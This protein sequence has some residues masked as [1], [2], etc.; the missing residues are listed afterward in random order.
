M[1]KPKSLVITTLL[2]FGAL[3]AFSQEK[4]MS[5]K[6]IRRANNLTWEGNQE[7]R[8]DNFVDAEAKY[9]T[10]I[11]ANE[12]EST[13]KYNLGNTYFEQKSYEEALLSYAKAA[14]STESELDKHRAFHN[15]GNVMMEKKD[16]AKAVEAYKNALRN[17]P[18]DDESRYNLAL[19]KKMLDQQKQDQEKNKDKSQDQNDQ[20]KEDK[21]QNQDK[22]DDKG[23]QKKDDQGDQQKGDD[24]KDENGDPKDEGE[25]EENKKGD[26]GDKKKET[27][28]KPKDNKQPP[29]RKSQLSPQQIKNLLEAMQNEERKSKEKMDAKKVK[30][31]PVKTKKDW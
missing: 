16:Y 28:Q 19:A 13:P 3:S 22:Q 31:V 25:K 2:F 5:P 6:E 12:K 10:A 23:D 7:M 9:R 30:G 21:D 4:P 14:S 11:S 8:A 29:P 27:P 20:D 24:K 26:Q 1:M 18:A 15:L 17:N